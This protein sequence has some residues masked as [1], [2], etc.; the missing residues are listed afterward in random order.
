MRAFAKITAINLSLLSSLRLRGPLHETRHGAHALASIISGA[1]LSCSCTY[2]NSGAIWNNLSGQH[3]DF[4]SPFHVGM[5]SHV[6][7]HEVHAGM[8][9]SFVILGRYEYQI[10]VISLSKVCAKS[11]ERW[12]TFVESLILGQYVG[13][14]LN[15]RAFS[16]SFH[17]GMSLCRPKRPFT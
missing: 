13:F 10:A 5:K 7:R 1:G 16:P 2:M 11:R 8:E 15:R 6:G 4:L 9:F 14:H 3:E 12:M 17:T